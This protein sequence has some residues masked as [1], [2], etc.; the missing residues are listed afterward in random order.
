M[1]RSFRR[2]EILLP[3]RFNDGSPVPGELVAD[4]LLELRQR[5]PQ[6][7]KQFKA[8]GNIRIRSIETI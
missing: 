6:R 1:S 5:C 2:F 7:L 3:L 8:C 4:T